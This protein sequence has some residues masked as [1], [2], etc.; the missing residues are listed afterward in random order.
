MVLAAASSVRNW[1]ACTD[2][3]CES[4]LSTCMLMKWQ[5]PIDNGSFAFERYIGT[6]ITA[7]LTFI[8]CQ[9]VADIHFSW[10]N[11]HLED[12]LHALF[13]DNFPF[14]PPFVRVVKP[15][16]HC[17]CVVSGGAICMELVSRVGWSCVYCLESLIIQIAATLVEGKA[18]VHHDSDKVL[19]IDWLLSMTTNRAILW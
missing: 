12:N 9:F 10:R 7:S 16:I 3:L 1:G 15:S 6:L 17:T 18:Y 2:L 4:V 5:T 19:I 13:Q 8:A 14:E 11:C